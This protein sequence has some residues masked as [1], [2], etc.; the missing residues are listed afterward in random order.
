MSMP[1]VLLTGGAGYVGSH[2]AKA[3]ACAG[4]RPV[5]FDNCAKGHRSAV[6]W[7]PLVV[8]D[9][10]DRSL[11]RETI[12]RYDVE[13]VIHFAADAYVGESMAQPLKYFR[14]NI[15]NTLGLLEAQHN[16][17]T[18]CIVFSSSCATY[19]TPVKMP[20]PEDHVQCPVNPYGESKLVVERMLHWCGHAYGL[21]WVALRYFNAAG[22]DPAGEIGECHDPETHLI[23]L[24]VQAAAGERSF[25][26]IMG[27]DYPTPDGTAVRETIHVADLADAHVRALEH[28]RRGGE[29]RAF[30][31]GTGRGYSVREIIA[32]VERVSGGP[33][34]S[35]ECPRRPGDPAT[36]IADSHAAREVL[37]WKPVH[38]DLE[39]IVKTTWQ[40]QLAAH[41]YPDANASV[42]VSLGCPLVSI[43][44]PYYNLE[45]YVAEAVLSVKRQ[46]YQNVEI[47]VV[48]DG[49]SVPA[50]VVLRGFEGIRILRIANSGVSAA[51]NF[52]FGQSKGEYV[53]FLDA[54]D[55]LLPKAIESHVAICAQRPEAGVI[56]GAVRHINGRGEITEDPTYVDRATITFQCFWSAIPLRRPARLW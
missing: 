19:G 40:W 26:E 16:L 54:D 43:V 46:T 44:I 14:N 1:T 47:I 41:S 38:S 13:A 42:S 37:G 25:V 22:A 52:G 21:R 20:I 3:L 48:D 30:N 29:S 23:P 51:R 27:N 32:T 8:G 55:Q 15:A 56:F 53:V 24:V 28:L 11:V 34:T 45:A 10:A 5:V 6:K 7:G 2:T 49:S 18:K 31:L 36:L 4:F 9:L 12:S 33:I 39:V 17:G 50:D 35:R